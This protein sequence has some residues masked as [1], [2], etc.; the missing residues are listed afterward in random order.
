MKL[1]LLSVAITCLI[2]TVLAG[3]LAGNAW[4][5]ARSWVIVLNV[6][7]SSLIGLFFTLVLYLRWYFTGAT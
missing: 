4:I 2:S 5:M 1:N 3:D 7:G 6:V